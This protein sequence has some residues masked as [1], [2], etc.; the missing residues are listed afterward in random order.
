MIIWPWVFFALAITSPGGLAMNPTLGS[1]VSDNPSDTTWVVS[2]LTN[3][4]T[5][6]VSYLFSSAVRTLAIKW[7][8]S[9]RSNIWTLTFFSAAQSPSQTLPWLYTNRIWLITHPERFQHAFVL[10]SYFILIIGSELDFTS[11]D[12]DCFFWFENNAPPD[13]CNWLSFNGQQF[14]TCL[15]QELIDVLGLARSYVS[16]LVL[17]PINYSPNTITLNALGGL[18]FADPLRGVLPGG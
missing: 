14:T 6:L 2:T 1:I 16:N 8:G 18:V 5:M 15:D 17:T 7:L 11:T 10:V 4:L 9:R 13:E 3:M 12:P